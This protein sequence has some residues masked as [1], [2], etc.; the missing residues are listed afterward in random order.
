[1]YIML[2]E[3]SNAHNLLDLLP[4]V[5][6]TNCRRCCLATDDRHVDDL[7][8]EGSI[9]YMVEAG[10]IHGYKVEQLLT[11]ATLKRPNI[12]A[13]TTWALWHRVIRRISMFLKI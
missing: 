5:N 3:G 10:V 7:I 9:N 1:M 11:M 12:F 2:R 4:L 8:G 13:A 6:E